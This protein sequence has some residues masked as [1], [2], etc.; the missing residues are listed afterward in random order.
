MPPD[1]TGLPPS[2]LAQMSARNVA[3]EIAVR[4]ISVPDSLKSASAP[5]RV[6]GT[7]AGQLPDGTLQVQTERGIVTMLLRDRGG[8][9][10]G[11]QIEIEI[12]AGK[13]PQQ[14]SVRPA[15]QQPPP[16]TS[17]SAQA[18]TSA[19]A[20]QN[21]NPAA[22]YA[23]ASSLRLDR[24]GPV[25]PADIQAA[26]SEA[27]NASLTASAASSAKNLPVLSPGLSVRLTP[28]P[29][30]H[31][32]L[33]A[34][35]GGHA[36][37]AS[38][39]P[40]NSG[41]L[42]LATSASLAMNL[43]AALDQTAASSSTR[44]AIVPLLTSALQGM[45]QA[46]PENAP[47]IP[48]L[49]QLIQNLSLPIDSEEFSQNPPLV[50]N[51]VQAVLQSARGGQTQS[52]TP[53]PNFGTARPVDAQVLTFLTGG[54][55]Q[56]SPQASPSSV[57]VPIPG[58]QNIV[59]GQMVV[60]GNVPHVSG[61]V[62]G[63]TPQN[64]A[65]IALP[66]PLPSPSASPLAS[67]PTSPTSPTLSF[68]AS[69]TT[70]PALYILPAQSQN[71]PVGSP[72]MLSILPVSK[73]ISG[74][75]QIVPGGVASPFQGGTW[76][77][78]QDLLQ[79]VS[80]VNPGLA[81]GIAQ[82]L[83]PTPTQPGAMGPLALFFLSVLR[84][85]EMENWMPPA[86]INLLRQSGA[87]GDSALRAVT[88]DMLA[89]AKLDG[90]PLAQDWRGTMIPLLWDN[91]VYKLPLYYRHMKDE[92]SDGKERRNRLLRFLFELKLSR[93][94]DV[95][96]DGFMQPER[97]DMILRTKSPLSVPMQ[98]AMKHLYTKAVDK[99]HLTGELTFQFK[100]DQWVDLSKTDT[101]ME[102]RA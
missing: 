72:V 39:T 80:L 19:A 25:I 66:S 64:L 88:G 75:L 27:E 1:L 63:F 7:V 26:L 78:L 69:L 68:G 22:S 20:A 14:G 24:S 96:V 5:T 84:S 67:L 56:T 94:G 8:L 23:G 100:P 28:L 70:Q 65:I 38:G 99:S 49:T 50:K 97:L 55:I 2:A 59:L 16:Q 3:Q 30:S 46:L 54:A 6:T 85:G 101:G 40:V 76:D 15:P 95:Q 18:L 74:G 62:V 60:Q 45:V 81:Q 10:Q 93:M 9:P 87:R 89:A 17:A 82:N 12:P 4:L 44:N 41:S 35:T 86:A 61:Q 98:S 42:Q 36:G 34:L 57:T 29:D 31:A 71:L 90:T 58:G 73:S 79:T 102:I 21:V 77:S 47:E 48:Q 51:T 53:T 52:A 13:N 37:T 32:A 91:Q 83:L 92:D 43:I 11:Q 33:N